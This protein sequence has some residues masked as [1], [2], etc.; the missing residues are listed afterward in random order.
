MGNLHGGGS[1]PSCCAFPHSVAFVYLFGQVFVVAH[2]LVPL[3]A[4][5]SLTAGRQD[6]FALL[7]V[8][9]GDCPPCI[10]SQAS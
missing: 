1:A 4:W 5:A 10:G 9:G 8:R 3:G 7:I 2:G 6:F